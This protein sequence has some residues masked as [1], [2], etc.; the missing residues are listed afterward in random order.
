MVVYLRLKLL[1]IKKAYF[2]LMGVTSTHTTTRWLW[3]ASAP[4]KCKAFFWLLIHNR[5]NTRK[6]LQMIVRSWNQWIIKSIVQ[7]ITIT[8][9]QLN[10]LYRTNI[11][12]NKKKNHIAD[13]IMVMA[14]R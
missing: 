14:S 8:M 13:K 5:L 4:L 2:H 10:Y 6:L 12:D 1:L 11:N 3:A 7:I 9:T